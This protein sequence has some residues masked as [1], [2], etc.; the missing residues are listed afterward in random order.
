MLDNSAGYNESDSE[1]LKGEH[2]KALHAA[3]NQLP[4]NQRTA[5]ILNK[6]EELSYKEI[7]LI[8]K[9]SHS[10]VESL[11]FRAKQNLQKSLFN[12]YQN[13]FD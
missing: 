1:I 12:Y 3:L 10:S 13:I 8:M 7:S 9:L 2:A 6:Y 4:A 11:I 5:F